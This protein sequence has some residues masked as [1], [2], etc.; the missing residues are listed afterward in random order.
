[1]GRQTGGWLGGALGWL[2]F[3][4]VPVVLESLHYGIVNLS[5]DGYSGPDPFDWNWFKWVALLGPLLGFGFLAGATLDL[6]DD[7]ATRRW[8]SRRAVWVAVGPWAGLV[9]WWALGVVITFVRQTFPQLN[10]IPLPGWW[11]QPASEPIRSIVWVIGVV[12]VTVT[13]CYPWIVPAVAALRR[14]RRCGQMKRSLERGLVVMIAFVG[15]LFGTFWAIVQ[16]C[17]SYFFDKTIIP[18]LFAALA[19]TVVSGCANTVTYGE[20][21]RRELFQALLVSWVFGLAILWRWWSRRRP[22]P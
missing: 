1:M 2:V 17:R 10:N 21:R 16:A 13:L 8:R 9:A 12:F 20:V 4:V 11:S 6:P 15:S 18:I 14:A 22:K 5:F 7:P 3:P 19:V